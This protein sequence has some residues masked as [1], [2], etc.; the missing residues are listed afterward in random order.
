VSTANAEVSLR[1]PTEINPLVE[2]RIIDPVRNSY[3]L[4][5]RREVVVE[6]L[7]RFRAP[8]L[9]TL[10]ESSDEFAALGVDADD[11][12]F[13]GFIIAAL[14]PDV[15]K[16]SVSTLWIGHFARGRFNVLTILSQ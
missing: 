9:T 7:D 11:W 6:D 16:L 5:S 14:A 3:P 13:F 10:V 4:S 12:K 15:V 8:A 1:V 2:Q